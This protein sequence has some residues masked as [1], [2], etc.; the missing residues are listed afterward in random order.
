MISNVISQ[1]LHIEIMIDGIA[2]DT[3]ACLYLLN[4]WVSV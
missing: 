2:K 3:H 1:K 4:Q